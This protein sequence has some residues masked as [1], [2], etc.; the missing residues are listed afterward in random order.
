M[1]REGTPEERR[2]V[3]DLYRTSLEQYRRSPKDAAELI[4]V[5]EAP[6]P[7]GAKPDELA[8]MTMVARALLNMH[9]TITRN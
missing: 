9:E 6:V 5:G 7:A 3:A 4:H 2:I 8:A 1:D